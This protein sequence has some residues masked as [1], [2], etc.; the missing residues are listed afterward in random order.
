MYKFLISPVIYK[1]FNSFSI[2]SDILE[3]SGREEEFLLKIYE[4][5]KFSN[6]DLL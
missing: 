5:H 4:W 3:E 2:E 6:L 1:S